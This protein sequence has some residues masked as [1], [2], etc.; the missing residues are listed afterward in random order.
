[1]TGNTDITLDFGGGNAS[2]VDYIYIQKTKENVEVSA[3]GFATYVP[4]YDLDFS[5]TTIEAYKVKVSSKGLATLT[6]VNEVPAGT[7]VL[8]YANDGATENIPV[9]TSADAVTDNDLV[10]GTGAAVA[11]TSG[12]YT[13]M[14]LNVVDKQI[15]FYFAND[16]TVATDRAYLHIASTLAPA[17]QQSRMKMVFAGE[18]TGVKSLPTS[19][20][21]EESVYNL[22]GQRVKKPTK[23]LYVK[24]GKKV[25]VK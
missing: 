8:L 24:G 20:K 18:T 11:T 10:A 19:Q 22:A 17:A 16:Q 14:I 9:I 4:A 12:D 2:G 5:S 23:G 21:G 13:N 25:I 1:M 15:G 6:K 7:P 3:A